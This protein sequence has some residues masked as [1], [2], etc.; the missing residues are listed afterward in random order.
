[1]GNLTTRNVRKETKSQRGQFAGGRETEELTRPI[2]FRQISAWSLGSLSERLNWSFNSTRSTYSFSKPKNKSFNQRSSST[3]QNSKTSWPVP[4]IDSIFQSHFKRA[5]RNDEFVVDKVIAKGA[6]G[7]V[8]KI[9][10]K[11]NTNLEYALKVLSKSK[12]IQ[13]NSV[14]QLK[15]EVDIQ[16]ICSHHQFIV[17]QLDAWQNRRHLHILLEYIPGGELFS[18][19]CRFPYE[20]VRLYVAE[21]SLAIDFLHNAGIIFRDV[22]PENILLTADYHIKLTDFGLSKWLKFGER[23]KTMCGTFQYMAPEILNGEMYGHAVDWWAIGVVACRMF[24]NEYPNTKLIT[25][26]KM[27]E[28]QSDESKNYEST[29]NFL[30]PEVDL[31]PKPGKD[32]LLRLL[33]I[34]PKFRLKSVLGLRKIAMF[35]DFDINVE[36]LKEISPLELLQKANIPSSEIFADSTNVSAIESSAFQ[37]F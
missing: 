4:L 5:S 16:K 36:T 23:T 35:K 20:L 7:I 15:D 32:L 14:Q 1:M 19:I 26:S 37:H 33:E 31:I 30:P 18:R 22:K 8:F 29:K 9:V 11:N 21:I 25:T 24:T 28:F 34:D 17:K 10:D 13:N 2:N 27:E 3:R 12:V 6:F